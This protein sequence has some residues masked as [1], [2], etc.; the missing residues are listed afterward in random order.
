MLYQPSY[1][2]SDVTCVISCKFWSIN[3]ALLVFSGYKQ[4]PKSINANRYLC[5]VAIYVCKY[6][7]KYAYQVLQFVVVYSSVCMPDLQQLNI[8]MCFCFCVNEQKQRKENTGECGM[9]YTAAQQFLVIV[10]IMQKHIKQQERSKIK[11]IGHAH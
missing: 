3:S 6:N 10:Q 2:S 8:K 11:A 5:L 7:N 9:R 1:I 4:E